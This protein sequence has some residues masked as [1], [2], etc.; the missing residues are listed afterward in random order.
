MRFT[1]SLSAASVSAVC[2]ALLLTA[3]TIPGDLAEY[4]AAQLQIRADVQGASMGLSASLLP[5]DDADCSAIDDDVSGRANDAPLALAEGGGTEPV[6]PSRGRLPCS[7]P[8]FEGTAPW[9]PESSV[10]VDDA[11]H[12]IATR[13]AAERPTFDPGPRGAPGDLVVLGVAPVGATSYS[14]T[15][16][17]GEAGET[18]WGVEP[19]PADRS[20]VVEIPT[21]DV[22]PPGA[23][24]LRI[25]LETTPAAASCDGVDACTITVTFIDDLTVEVA[26][27]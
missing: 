5:R 23:R 3:C 25:W 4:D 11:S 1:S 20:I 16:N 6:R 17:P 24:V 19:L 2:L 27:E 7:N 26:V 12:S 14:I 15:W 9:R 10:T 8:W 18:P 13:F 22:A 21:A